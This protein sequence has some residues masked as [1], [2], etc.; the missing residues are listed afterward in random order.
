M[1]IEGCIPF[2]VFRLFIYFAY[3]LIS[4]AT[5]QKNF[6]VKE[7]WTVETFIIMAIILESNWPE[8][9]KVELFYSTQHYY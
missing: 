3:F 9:N 4:I 2:G 8:S 1:D 5:N 7:R 6:T